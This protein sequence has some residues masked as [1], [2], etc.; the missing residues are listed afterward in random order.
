MR[1]WL[2]SGVVAL[3]PLVRTA[4]QAP[5]PGWEMEMKR[6]ASRCGMR[7]SLSLA[8][9]VDGGE[10]RAVVDVRRVVDHVRERPLGGDLILVAVVEHVLQGGHR[11]DRRKRL[12][13]EARHGAA[14]LRVVDD[15]VVAGVDGLDPPALIAE[16]VVLARY[17]DQHG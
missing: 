11:R 9:T 17:L 16:V 2:L 4:H 5:E 6:L 8:A 10:G 1:V 15:L 13:V 14:A 3:V 12:E 7:E